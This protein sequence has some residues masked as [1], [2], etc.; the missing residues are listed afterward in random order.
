MHHIPRVCAG[1]M[2]KSKMFLE[3]LSLALLGEHDLT[4]SKPA[5]DK[6]D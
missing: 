5:D 3:I 2:K 4:T 1:K 6:P